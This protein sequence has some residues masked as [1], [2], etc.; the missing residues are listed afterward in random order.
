M[1]SKLWNFMSF[2]F[3]IFFFGCWNFFAFSY[4]S[5]HDLAY[6]ST[7]SYDD[8]WNLQYVGWCWCV[9]DNASLSCYFNFPVSN[10]CN[11]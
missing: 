9:N 8:K 2:L 4:L 11:S 7:M 3:S 1:L 10:I 5:R 6:C